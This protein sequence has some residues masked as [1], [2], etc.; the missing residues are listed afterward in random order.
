MTV[1]AQ[2]WRQCLLSDPRDQSN[3]FH[4]AVMPCHDKKLEAMILC[5]NTKKTWM[6]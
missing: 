4:L 3:L 1:V 2:F 6:W 5:D